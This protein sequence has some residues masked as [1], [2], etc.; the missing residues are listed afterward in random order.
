MCPVEMAMPVMIPSWPSPE[1]VEPN[2]ERTAPVE[3]N[4]HD[5]PAGGAAVGVQDPH[6]AFGVDRHG[7]GAEQLPGDEAR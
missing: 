2:L 7:S 1:P 6:V 3:E 5:A 4:S